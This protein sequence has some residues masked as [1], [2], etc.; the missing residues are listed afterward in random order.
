MQLLIK[1]HG[2]RQLLISA[3]SFSACLMKIRRRLSCS[4]HV[5]KEPWSTSI[6]PIL[7]LLPSY[8]ASSSSSPRPHPLRRSPTTPVSVLA[9]GAVDTWVSVEWS[10]AITAG[11][12]MSLCLMKVA[13]GARAPAACRLSSDRFD[14]EKLR[15][16]IKV[17]QQKGIDV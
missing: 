11:Y 16:S 3:S 13:E 10:R 12:R 4:L 7:P 15:S 1:S 17:W 14:R 6:I 2:A 8:F 9:F 5:W